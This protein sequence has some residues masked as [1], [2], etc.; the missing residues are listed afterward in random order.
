[1]SF[2]FNGDD[3]FFILEH[4]KGA[5]FSEIGIV[6]ANSVG[7]AAAKINMKI[8]DIVNPPESAVIFAQLENEYCLTEMSEITSG[9]E[10]PT[11]A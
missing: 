6:V 1:M 11:S 3:M 9:A 4:K 5:R 10:I 2:T 7:E 8:V